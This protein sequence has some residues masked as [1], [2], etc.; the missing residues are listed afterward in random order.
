DQIRREA[1]ERLLSDTDLSLD[2][3]S[4]QLG[5]AEQSVFTRSC[6]RWFGTTPSAY[7]SDRRRA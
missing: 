6:K 1:A 5:Y 4:R 2:H 7:R 3:L